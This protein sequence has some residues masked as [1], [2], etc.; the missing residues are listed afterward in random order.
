MPVTYSF[1]SSETVVNQ[2]TAAFQGNPYIVTLS[3]GSYVIVWNDESATAGDTDGSAVRAQLYAADGS[4]IGS[5]F[6]I[7]QQT[8]NNQYVTGLTALSGG[9]FVVTWSS[10][11]PGDTTSG[12]VKARIFTNAGAALGVE[13]MVPVATA[14]YQDGAALAGLQDGG[15]IAVWTDYGPSGTTTDAALVGQRFSA[16]GSRVGDPFDVANYTD[17]SQYLPAITVLSDG[18]FVVS[19][20]DFVFGPAEPTRENASAGIQARLFSSGATPQGTQFA[21]NDF[22]FGSQSNSSIAALATGGFVIVWTDSAGDT[23]IRGRVYDTSGNPLAGSF[24]ANQT[25]SGAQ[26]DG[27][28]ISWPD[29]GFMI[30]W[31]DQSGTSGELDSA[32]AA[33][34]FSDT[35]VPT[36]DEQRLNNLL[37]GN[38][39]AQAA[40]TLADGTLVAAWESIS[41]NNSYDGSGAAVQQRRFSLSANTTGSGDVFGTNGN[42]QLTASDSGARLFAY[43]GNDVLVSAAG[44][45]SLYGG[46]GNDT[47]V[48]NNVGD[49]VF[50]DI[51]RGTDTVQSSISW[52]LGSNFE[53]LTLTGGSP[54]SATGNALAN[55]II[56]NAAASTLTGGA[57]NDRLVVSAA[58]SGS[59]IDGGTDIDT[60][61]VSG[62]VSLGSITSVEAIELTAGANLTLTT[63]QVMS[64]LAANTS[65]SGT[66]T[67]T[68]NLQADVFTAVPG[69]VNAGGSVNFIYSGSAGSDYV[70]AGHFLNTIS[71]GVGEDF[72]RGGNGIDAIDGGADRDKIT[73]WG[74]ADILTGGGG[75]DQFRYLYATDSGVGAAADRITDF[76]IGGDV[77]DLRLLDADLVTPDIQSY[78]LSFIGS[79][80]FGAAGAGQIRYGT[81]GSN[82]VVQMDLD[83]NGSSDMEILLQ[84]LVGQTLSASDFLFAS[85]GAEPLPPVKGVGPEV[86]DPLLAAAKLPAEGLA[87]SDPL[88]TVSFVDPIA[89]PD[90]GLERWPTAHWDLVPLG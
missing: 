47:Y 75:N 69:F 85:A 41:N 27:R 7:N 72:V 88:L 70:K 37:P 10:N 63:S 46:A 28:V 68:I 55:I 26:Q 22:P 77:I 44:N 35:G 29:G 59:F 81:S 84:G 5:E 65:V 12:D 48:V 39:V 15:F 73:G 53:I 23:N 19:W 13:F 16:N 74:G 50:E 18:R 76:T 4:A 58:G 54:L 1:E 33:R 30:L 60:L 40:T 87:S 57:G 56:G 31:S 36:G 51:G 6:L 20:T 8:T 17:G 52:M 79:A 82:M 49:L 67:V 21:V 3:N 66:G 38:Q 78:A 89:F 34:T 42:D 9:G 64:G 80:A 14:G 24:I 71:G 2:T 25:T 90:H 11:I 45:D 61:A 86:M 62:A 43:G 83:G 32:V